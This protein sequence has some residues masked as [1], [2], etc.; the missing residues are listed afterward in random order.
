MLSFAE[1]IYLLALDEDSCKII[2]D[3]RDSVLGA[4][5]IGAILTE[6]TFLRKISTDKEHLYIQNTTDTK[7]QILNDVLEILKESHQ[8]SA[9]IDEVLQALMSHAKR[10]EKMVLSELIEKEVLKEIDN[11]ILW[12]FHNRRYPLFNGEEIIDV[13]TRIRRLIL[14]D[15]KP[16]P[17]DAALISLM[18]ATKLFSKILSEEEYIDYRER[19]LDLSQSSDIG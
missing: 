7:S 2:P 4:A 6:L 9:R 15:D 5:I 16:A 13:E 10:L 12:I 3:A 18:Q 14:S 17:K 1:E 19:I 11:K 8:K